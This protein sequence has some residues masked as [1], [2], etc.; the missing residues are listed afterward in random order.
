MTERK[1]SGKCCLISCCIVAFCKTRFFREVLPDC[2][3][4]EEHAPGRFILSADVDCIFVLFV[5]FYY[6]WFHFSGPSNFCAVEIGF[7]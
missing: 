1:I 7:T 5:K 2:D 4:Y 3:D 6:N